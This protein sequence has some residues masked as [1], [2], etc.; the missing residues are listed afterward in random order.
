[1]RDLDLETARPSLRVKISLF[2]IN[3]PSL[4]KLKRN[5]SNQ[6]SNQRSSQRLNQK[7]K[8]IKKSWKQTRP[9]SLKENR[10][11]DQ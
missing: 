7:L 4:N 1:M 6:K 8:M 2:L 5:L 3:L 11:R 10:K 9:R